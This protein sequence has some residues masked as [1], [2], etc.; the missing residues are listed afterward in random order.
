MA[1]T[2]LDEYAGICTLCGEFSRFQHLGGSPRE[3]YRCSK[4][5][6]SI[7]ERGLA[8]TVLDLHG[9]GQ[10][11]AREL[12][13]SPRFASLAIY[14]PGFNG[15]IRRHVGDLPN[16]RYSHYRA[17]AIPGIRIDGVGNEDLQRLTFRSESF[18]LVLTSDILE[19]VRRPHEAFAEIKRVLKIGGRHVFTVP[20]HYPMR[21][22]TEYRVD[23]SSDVDVPLLPAAYHGDG[24]GGKSLVYTDFGRD[25]MESLSRLNTPTT[26][27]FVDASNTSRRKALVFVSTRVA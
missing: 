4:C 5:S 15:T 25:M 23:T 9:E 21:E 19:H 17:E 11:C 6:S 12:A 22:R 8:Q 2:L 26:V 20:L 18:D 27:R 16:Y 24:R 13:L 14:E 3:S 1:A 10:S 7:R